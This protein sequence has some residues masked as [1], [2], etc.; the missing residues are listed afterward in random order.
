MIIFLKMMSWW[1]NLVEEE[2]HAGVFTYSVKKGSLGETGRYA[3]I[4]CIV[5]DPSTIGA[6]VFRIIY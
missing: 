5:C 1:M 4:R 3:E 2:L 6:D